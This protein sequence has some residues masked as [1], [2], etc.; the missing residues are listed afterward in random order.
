MILEGPYPERVDQNQ[1]H[2]G[3]QDQPG[4][5]TR[6]RGRTHR[7]VIIGAGYAGL[8]AATRLA[9]QVRPDEVRITLVAETPYFLERPRLHQL[10]VGQ[11]IAVV[12]LQEFLGSGIELVTGSVLRIDLVARRLLLKD[13]LDDEWSLSYHTLVY[14]TGSNI[15]TASVPGVADHASSLTG[16]PAAHVL[17]QRLN[18]LDPAAPVLVC[19]GGLTGIETAAEIAESYPKLRT[20]LVSA[21]PAGGWLSPAARGYLDRTFDRL[22]I[23]RIEGVRVTR[24]DQ[25][26]LRLDDE[27]PRSG[28]AALDY[29]L[30]VWAAGFSV[31]ELARRAGLTVNSAGR[32]IVDRSLESVSHPG[33]YAIGDAA[34]VSGPWGD[35]IAMGCRS[36]GFTGPAVADIIA[37]RLTGRPAQQFSFRYLHECISLGRRH[38]LIQFLHADESPTD[39]ILTGRAAIAY[40]NTVLN[41]ATF[42]FRHPGPVLPRRR[43]LV[44]P[45][46]SSQT[47]ATP[48]G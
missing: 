38:G 31:S 15:D 25:D 40:K 39:V 7:V 13:T 27:L 1:R 20:R 3:S 8:V 12:G 4:R 36:G 48:G 35:E 29:R 33:V 24:V 21:E 17:H 19:G 41:T 14:A 10:A 42:L 44:A 18:R 2:H 23:E 6:D 34:A 11:S 9:R 22:G 45:V 28:A 5:R 37:A 46:V 32:V 26:R 16:R 43:R 30:C 47:P